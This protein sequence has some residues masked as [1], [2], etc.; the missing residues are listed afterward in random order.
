MN[1]ENTKIILERIDGLREEMAEEFKS[2]REE[3]A[4]GFGVLRDFIEYQEGVNARQEQVNNTILNYIESVD[5]PALETKVDN[6][7]MRI[8]TLERLIAR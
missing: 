5:V 6:H 3:M 8:L 1:D 4:E 2:V 7:S